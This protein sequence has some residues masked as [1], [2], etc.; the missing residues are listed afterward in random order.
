MRDRVLR[1]LL[2][3]SNINCKAATCGAT[4]ADHGVANFIAKVPMQN[5]RSDIFSLSVS[6]TELVK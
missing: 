6:Q 2:K 3:R 4:V 1:V 5:E